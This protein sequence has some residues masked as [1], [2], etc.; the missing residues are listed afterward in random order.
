M[1]EENTLPDPSGRSGGMPHS[2]VAS[3]AAI[4][5]EGY[6]QLRLRPSL[7]CL[8]EVMELYSLSRKDEE[9]TAR[10]MDCGYRIN[11][12]R[13]NSTDNTVI[14]IGPMPFET[15]AAFGRMAQK[16]EL[17]FVR[18]NHFFSMS[19]SDTSEPTLKRLA[20]RIHDMS[21]EMEACILSTV[22]AETYRELRSFRKEIKLTSLLHQP[23]YQVL[24]QE[25]HGLLQE[26]TPEAARK[27]LLQ[28]ME[29]AMHQSHAIDNSELWTERATSSSNHGLPGHREA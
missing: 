16:F 7:D 1:V 29:E 12:P 21:Q 18:K 22:D 26:L 23:Q 14:S 8:A 28:T 4:V 2:F 11:G 15:A 13:R 27:L 3:L 9:M 25:M 24:L 6:T 5:P 20:G 10:Y 19:I 17:P